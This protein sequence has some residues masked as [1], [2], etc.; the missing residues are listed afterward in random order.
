MSLARSVMVERM[1]AS[2]GSYDGR[3]ITGVMTTGIYCLPSCGARKPKP[4][5]V[6]FHPSPED[7]RAAGLRPCKRCR[8]DDFYRQHHP[9]EV[10]V[11][12]LVGKVRQ[13]PAAFAGVAALVRSSG[14]GSSKLNQLFRRHLHSTPARVLNDARID[15]AC[16]LL[17]NGR[18]SVTRIAYEVGYESLSSFNDNFRRR[19][20]MSP[21]EYRKLRGTTEFFLTLPHNFHGR[22][23]LAELRRAHHTPS[24]RFTED[25]LVAALWCDGRPL[26]L[27]LSVKGRSVRAKLE[28]RGRA[29]G[30]AAVAGH[31]FAMRRLG[32]H[33]SPAGFERLV[34]AEPELNPLVNGSRGRRFP[35]Y[36]DPFETL[37]WA[38]VGQQVTVSFAETL[39]TRLVELTGRHVAG[40]L[41]TPPTAES[42]AEL[43]IGDL[44]KLQFSLRKAEYLIDLARQISEGEL[45]LTDL[46]RG[47]A[48]RAERTLMKLRGLG[49]WSVNYL[50]MRGFGFEDCVPLG[51]TGLTRALWNFFQLE[52]RPG[53]DETRELMTRFSPYRTWA[54]HHLWRT[55]SKPAQAKPAQKG[56]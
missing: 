35:L 51:D 5:N 24:E 9:N 2:D 55:F 19:T 36:G 46:G 3:F 12:E 45:S 22:R 29:L 18:R 17:V 15:R 23:A 8:P 53:V 7:A 30:G 39:F 40:G 20:A 52:E 44:V 27:A 11:E 50:M 26:R 32:L 25:G 42:V 6:R 14:V 28:G 4:E 41:L 54:T 38:V 47:T 34:A 37:C 49:P 48:T 16:G 13:D 43:R 21:S 31:H 10:L 1:L 33:S 56:A